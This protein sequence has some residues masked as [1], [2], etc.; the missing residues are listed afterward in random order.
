MKKSLGKK[1]CAAGLMMIVVFVTLNVVLT[2]FFLIPFSTYLSQKQME[3]M[4]IFLTE[5]SDY[6]NDQF[7]DVIEQHDEDENMQI[8]IINANMDVICSTKASEY[9]NKT[10]SEK[11]MRLFEDKFEQIEHGEMIS[12]VGKKTDNNRITVR[13]IKKV[14]DD[15]Y[16][17]LFRSYRSLENAMHS[18]ILFNLIAGVCFILLG[19]VIVYRASRKLIIPIR[20]MTEIAEHISNLEFDANVSIQSEDELG[21]LAASINKMSDHLQT[22]L[23]ALQ[24]DIENRKRL[25]RNL[26]H[27]IKSPIAVI[28]GYADRMKAVVNK[29]PKRAIEYCEIISNESGRIDILVKEMLEVSRFEQRAEDLF[30]ENIDVYHFFEKVENRFREENFNRQIDFYT[31]CDFGDVVCADEI[32]LER[33]VFNLL[34]N[35]VTYGAKDSLQIRLFGKRIDNYYELRVYN[36]GNGIK[37]EYMDSIWDAF[38][39]VDKARTRGKQG[40]GVGLSI[41]REIVEVHNGYYMVENIEDGVEFTIAFR[42]I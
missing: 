16:A 29:N 15:R 34:N 20:K 13:V 1:I 18:A 17:I 5:Q 7:L 42:S 4:A 23:E 36:S 33:A 8:T 24:N 12:V 41:V 25:V 14:A 3:K 19:F 22:N 39:K 6:E 26:S 21:Q 31:K 38:V 35:A 40:S 30:I 9:R 27:E 11:T 32:L 28:M 10:L 37:Q 2:Y